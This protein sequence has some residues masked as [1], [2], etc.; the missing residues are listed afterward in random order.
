MRPAACVRARGHRAA[1]EARATPAAASGGRPGRASH[2]KHR[3]PWSRES[4]AGS[5]TALLRASAADDEAMAR[6]KAEYEEKMKDP[7]V[8]AQVE[9]MQKMMSSPQVQQQMQDQMKQFQSKEFQDKIEKMKDDP[10]LKEMF[11]E[12]KMGGMQAMMKYW[13][14]PKVLK[15]FSEKLGDGP[16]TAAPPPA[17]GGEAPA[18]ENLLD[19][20]KHGDMEAIEDYIAIGKD[21]NEGD[22]EARTPLHFAA[23]AG[24]LEI[25]RVLLD[26]G[27]LVDAKDSKDNT[28]LHYAAGYGRAQI[29]ALLV[30]RGTQVGL[31]N[32]NGK[33]AADLAGLNPDN[34]I[35]K[36]EALLAKLRKNST[37]AD[38]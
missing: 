26:E 2:A 30:E 15:K 20:A 13:N 6:A 29:A 21:V 24:H 9:G 37:F 31:L 14:D 17:S 28:P 3:V 23:G 35:L 25:C 32:A 18:A 22:K 5:R 7:Q 12:M 38:I 33:K 34:P 1:T 16:S 4:R 11:D 8:R 10:E 36:D 19:A 27:A